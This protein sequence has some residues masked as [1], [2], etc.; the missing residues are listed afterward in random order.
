M[1]RVVL[2]LCVVLVMFGAFLFS[3][4]GKPTFEFKDVFEV[5]NYM[6][7]MILAYFAWLGLADWK[8]EKR[9]QALKELRLATHGLLAG[10]LY[11]VRYRRACLDQHEVNDIMGFTDHEPAL[12]EL[13]LKWSNNFREFRSIWSAHGHLL[14]EKHPPDQWV[15]V[16][17]PEVILGRFEQA[18]RVID[19]YHVGVERDMVPLWSESAKDCIQR[20]TA[21]VDRLAE[22]INARVAK[23]MSDS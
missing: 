13:R 6:A 19:Q 8:R 16:I 9:F 2:L 23:M 11:L 20:F 4:W 3:A 1:D 18:C 21:C 22:P 17:N 12:E 14:A 10:S 5:L 15:E 7:T